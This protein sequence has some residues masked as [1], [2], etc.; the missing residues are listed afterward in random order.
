MHSTLEPNAVAQGALHTM[1]CAACQGAALIQ[2]APSSADGTKG[3]RSSIQPRH[4]I[5]RVFE[6]VAELFP[7]NIEP[8]LTLELNLWNTL[9]DPVQLEQVLRSLCE[10]A[11]DAMPDGGRLKI[12][13]KNTVIDEGSEESNPGTRAG[14]YIAIQVQDS[15][16]RMPPEILE[17]I[18]AAFPATQESG[19]GV[20]LS[21]SSSLAIVRSHGGFIRVDSEA[22]KGS[23]F[24]VHL[25]AEP[26]ANPLARE[27]RPARYPR[28]NG[29]WVM[30]VDDDA[31]IR[32][33]TQKTLEAFGYQVLLACDGA[34]AAALYADRQK[35]IAAVIVDM[36]MPVMDGPATIRMLSSINPD[37]K[38]IV[39]SG[40]SAKEALARTI[41]PNVKD[42]LPKPYNA[43]ALLK[44]V[45]C[46]LGSSEA[47]P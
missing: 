6:T 41:S 38:I 13:A 36:M 29:E 45:S 34:E 26:G 22:G 39:T 42:F 31:A 35:E 4:L 16:T 14:R 28:G 17:Q 15:S 21:L 44:V 25:P 43:A 18:F 20:R 8:E 19:K 40:I 3:G 7:R 32:K 47:V 11:R 46:A 2:R 24:K 23:I 12:S 5:E 27:A 37:V 33:I 9:G 1:E 30:M 10:N